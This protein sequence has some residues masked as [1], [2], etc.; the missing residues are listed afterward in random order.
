ML[1]SDGPGCKPFRTRIPTCSIAA[2][3]TGQRGHRLL[4]VPLSLRRRLR[5]CDTVGRLRK[6]NWDRSHDR[7][8]GDGRRPG[9]SGRV[10]FA[11][12]AGMVA[13]FLNVRPVRAA[14]A[15]ADGDHLR[16]AVLLDALLVG[17]CSCRSCCASPAGP[18]GGCRACSTGSS[19]TCASGTDGTRVTRTV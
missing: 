6:E 3:P 13:V 14:A 18:L 8:R 19:R 2:S 16:H 12:G 10:I 11:A 5:P 1:A 4:S 9:H 17:R 15:E 7:A